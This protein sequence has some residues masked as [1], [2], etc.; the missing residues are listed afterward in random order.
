MRLC[1]L[2]ALPA[3]Y[4]R[5]IND[6]LKLKSLPRLTN[7]SSSLK[8][9]LHLRCSHVSTMRAH[10]KHCFQRQCRR[11]RRKHLGLSAPLITIE[12]LQNLSGLHATVILSIDPS[13]LY[14]KF[15]RHDTLFFER[16]QLLLSFLLHCFGTVKDCL[17]F[18]LPGIVIPRIRFHTGLVAEEC[19]R[20]RPPLA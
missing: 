17:D 9:H 3:Q 16:V 14:H 5:R 4:A 10:S 2:P 13:R 15:R 19:V 1:H 11:C 20:S 18:R 6:V 8:S 7:S 12:V